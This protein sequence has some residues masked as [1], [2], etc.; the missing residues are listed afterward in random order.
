MLPMTIGFVLMGPISGI[1][2][3]KYGPRW[4]ATTGMVLVT[5][6]FI[7][8]ATL[9]YDFE[10]WQLGVLIFLIGCGNGMFA[11]PNSSSIMNSVPPQDRGVASGMMSTL[12]NSA[13]TASMAV[14][15]TIV[16][17]GIQGAFPAAVQSSLASLGSAQTGPLAAALGAIPPTGALFSAF[18]GYNPM[19][20]ILSALP[21][22]MLSGISQSAI[23]VLESPGW[24]PKTLAEAFMPSLRASFVIGAILCAVSAVLSAMR[25]DKY[26]HEASKDI[27][28]VVPEAI[29]P[30]ARK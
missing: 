22:Q 6:C 13:N 26:V 25:G 29:V 23:A 8:L 5:M 11:S 17:V 10:Y 21:A 1:L 14:F 30:E 16:I 15:F 2:S 9:N 20:S 28:A 7:G 19:D 18:L 12:M 4:I 27:K 24:F 3:D